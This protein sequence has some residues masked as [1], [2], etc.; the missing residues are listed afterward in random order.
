MKKKFNPKK[1]NRFILLSLCIISFIL[2]IILSLYYVLLNVN[3]QPK[4]TVLIEYTIEQG[5][6]Y[7]SIAK[8]YC[9]DNEDIRVLIYDMQKLNNIPAGDLRPGDVLEIP[10]EVKGD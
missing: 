5:D 4:T 3:T 7:W 8:E 1:F 6:T 9:S 2:L 10:V